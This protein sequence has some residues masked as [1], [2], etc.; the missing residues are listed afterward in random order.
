[1]VLSFVMFIFEQ[2]FSVSQDDDE[3][4]DYGSFSTYNHFQSVTEIKKP[5]VIMDTITKII[6]NEK[7]DESQPQNKNGIELE[8]GS[9]SVDSKLKLEDEV[10]EDLDLKVDEEVLGNTDTVVNESCIEFGINEALSK[11]EEIAGKVTTPNISNIDQEDLTPELPPDEILTEPPSLEQIDEPSCYINEIAADA[12]NSRYT[13]GLSVTE[14]G[15]K[16]PQEPV[17]AE[18]PYGKDSAM[19]LN[20]CDDLQDNDDFGDFDD[21]QFANVSDKPTIVIDGCE[22]PW[23]S[24]EQIDDDFGNFGDFKAS[25]DNSQVSITE[26]TPN[27]AP[28]VTKSD[29]HTIVEHIPEN[30]DFGDFNDF[31]SSTLDDTSV[32]IAVRDDDDESSPPPL[33]TLQTLENESEF[34]ERVNSLVNDIFYEEIPDHEEQFE[35]RLETQLSVTWGHLLEVDVR[36]P[37]MVNWNNSLAQK[38]LLKA[39]CIDSRNIVSGYLF[40]LLLL[41]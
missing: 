40:S 14:D 4:Y 41:C 22:N 38:T 30:D 15:Q 11:S 27:D 35:G 28:I 5:E 24:S 9:N 33:L 8:L 16:L 26:S 20:K 6:E 29:V 37:Y 10:I 23:G 32:E 36:Q 1:M 18:E 19:P 21:F 31:K 3:N 39:L 2:Y 17:H 34:Q 7:H 25:F 13:D 12:A